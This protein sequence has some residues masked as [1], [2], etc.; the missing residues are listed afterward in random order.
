MNSRI[1]PHSSSVELKLAQRRTFSAN[2]GSLLW[3]QLAK[4]GQRNLLPTAWKDMS[5]DQLRK[6]FRKKQ[7][8]KQGY[9]EIDFEWVHQ[10]LSDPHVTVN[11]LHEEYQQKAASE[12]LR[13]YSRTQFFSQYHA[14]CSD[15]K[16]SACFR[17]QEELPNPPQKSQYCTSRHHISN[18]GF[19]VEYP[20]IPLSC[21]C[22]DHLVLDKRLLLKRRLSIF[23]RQESCR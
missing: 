3:H 17:Y 22:E 19:R 12:G 1:F 5:E 6:V 23:H 15:V 9:L 21:F 8:P 18:F 10:E 4:V 14:Y 20:K 2:W 13:A 16:Y 7:E 11:L